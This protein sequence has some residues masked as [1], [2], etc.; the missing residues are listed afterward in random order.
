MGYG[1]IRK[2][3]NVMA[4][5]QALTQADILVSREKALADYLAMGTSRSLAKLNQ[6]YTDSGL[7]PPAMSTLKGWSSSQAWQAQAA[8]HDAIT[9]RAIQ[10]RLREK[11]AE[12]QAEEAFCIREG[13]D[14]AMTLSIAKALQ[15]IESTP[16]TTLSDAKKA[17]EVA[18]E[19][20]FLKQQL[21]DT[22][23]YQ[24]KT[25]QQREEEAKR[26]SEELFAQLEKTFSSA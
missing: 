4:T 11:E 21:A 6:H 8:E 3:M 14:R 9:E 1:T 13:L 24:G 12:R 19:I 15:A 20:L 18:K 16:A 26:E 10:E 25:Q 2:R 17:L 22:V 23:S 5:A 7:K